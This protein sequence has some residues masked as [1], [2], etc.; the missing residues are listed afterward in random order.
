MPFCMQR[1]FV[2]SE[3]FPEFLRQSTHKRT[4]RSSKLYCENCWK[5]PSSA[6]KWFSLAIC[7]FQNYSLKSK[8]WFLRSRKAL[9]NLKPN[10]YAV[11]FLAEFRLTVQES[12]QLAAHSNGEHIATFLQTTFFRLTQNDSTRRLIMVL[13]NA[14]FNHVETA[15]DLTK[16][17]NFILLYG[18]VSSL[19]MNSIEYLFEFLKRDLRRLTSATKYQILQN[20]LQQATLLLPG[21]VLRI[22]SRQQKDFS[23]I[24][25]GENIYLFG[26]DTEESQ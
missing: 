10:C 15:K 7:T 9:A 6:F 23:K 26:R 14:K 20:L 24:L 18:D 13:N 2:P 17:F 1:E 19:Q 16:Q 12:I 11:K 8:D 25:R 5:E 4:R 21:Q 22:W 3:R